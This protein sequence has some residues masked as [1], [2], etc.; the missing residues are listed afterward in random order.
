MLFL[1]YSLF[2]INN[3]PPAPDTLHPYLNKGLKGSGA[4]SRRGFWE[5]CE[6]CIAFILTLQPLLT[7][8]L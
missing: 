4:H 8:L 3:T 6:V 1:D 2:P 5:A 7:T